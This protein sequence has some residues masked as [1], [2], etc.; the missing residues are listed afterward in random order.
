MMRLSLYEFEIKYKPGPQN[1]LADF[2]SRPQENEENW[3]TSEDYLDQL[4]ASIE[5][6]SSIQY[7]L[8]MNELYVNL[9]MNE[10]IEEIAISEP[11]EYIA[12]EV[13]DTDEIQIDEINQMNINVIAS[14]PSSQTQ[15]NYRSYA[16]EQLKDEDIQWIK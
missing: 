15:D 13:N 4:V 2:L 8:A 14:E 7:Q 16:E 10:K 3:E 9:E 5:T 11:M 12:S 1:V 6:A